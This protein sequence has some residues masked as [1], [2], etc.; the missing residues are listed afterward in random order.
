M[1]FDQRR[2]HIRI[3]HFCPVTSVSGDHWDRFWFNLL[4]VDREREK[5]RKGLL[6]CCGIGTRVLFQVLPV[7]SVCRDSWNYS[8]PDDWEKDKELKVRK[9]KENERKIC[10][11][12]RQFVFSC[13]P[14][15][16]RLSSSPPS[17]LRET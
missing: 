12:D 10:S 6:T 1:D 7:V 4:L 2:S 9:E 8:S 17:F 5:E 13:C 11:K 3:P 14:H 16:R 15:E